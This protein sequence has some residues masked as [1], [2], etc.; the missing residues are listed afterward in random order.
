LY[1]CAPVYH[2]PQIIHR[3]VEV[4]SQIYG[5]P[6]ALDCLIGDECTGCRTARTQ[7]GERCNLLQ[8]EPAVVVR[9]RVKGAHQQRYRS[10]V[11]SCY[12][13]LSLSGI[14]DRA[15]NYT[16]LGTHGTTKRKAIAGVRVH[17]KTGQT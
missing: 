6:E 12:Q 2:S 10:T 17:Y 14:R 8:G 15:A 4:G 13:G 16:M 11:P 3:P 7:R 5:P 9:L 1:L